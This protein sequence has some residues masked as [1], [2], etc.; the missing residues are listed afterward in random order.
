MLFQVFFIFL[1]LRNCLPHEG[2]LCDKHSKSLLMVILHFA[3]GSDPIQSN[4]MKQ[5]VLSPIALIFTMLMI[6]E[7]NEQGLKRKEERKKRHA[8][9]SRYQPS[10]QLGLVLIVTI[11]KVLGKSPPPCFEVKVY[12]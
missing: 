4:Q 2:V 6:P 11:N 1:I 12:T 10:W 3:N 7:T 8:L 5:S 9:P